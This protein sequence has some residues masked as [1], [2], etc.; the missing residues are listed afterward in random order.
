MQEITKLNVTRQQLAEKHFYYYNGC[1]TAE[2]RENTAENE[3]LNLAVDV[4][5]D[6][7][8]LECKENEYENKSTGVYKI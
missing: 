2:I 6:I 5:I 4:L 3:I 8:N 1:E 7:L